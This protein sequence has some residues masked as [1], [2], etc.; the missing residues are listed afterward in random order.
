MTFHGDWCDG[1][2]L[3]INE[4]NEEINFQSLITYQIPPN[5][6]KTFVFVNKSSSDRV[7]KTIVNGN[8]TLSRQIKFPCEVPETPPEIVVDESYFGY[9]ED[10]D[11]AIW[12]AVGVS[13][14]LA[15]GGIGVGI[16]YLLL[17]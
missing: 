3:I 17:D 14:A 11:I 10:A 1:S 16:Y 9:G 7:I 12:T 5:S 13:A 15:L 8:K 2:I 6:S 4:E